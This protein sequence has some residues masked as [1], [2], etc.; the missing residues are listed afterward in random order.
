MTAWVALLRAVNVGGTGKLPMADLKSMGEACGLTQ[1]RTWIASGNLLFNSPL[2][3]AQLKAQI[4][5]RLETYA[6]KRIPVLL[7][8]ADQMAAI[9]RANPF[10]EANG[11]RH[12]VFFFDGTVPDDTA[13]R[14]RDVAEERIQPMGRELHVDYGA[15]I[16]HTRLKRPALGDETSRSF[17]TVAKLA[18]L[19]HQ[20]PP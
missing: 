15:G 17:N 6:G 16:R 20:T 10:P 19:L 12:L 13:A 14:C 8:T 9:V 4:E 1:V 11:S 3:E 2:S 7:R 5:A 18:H